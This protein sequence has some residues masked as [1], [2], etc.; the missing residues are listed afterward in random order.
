MVSSQRSEPLGAPFTSGT[1]SSGTY[2]S[3]EIAVE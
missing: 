2:T 3:R 1:F